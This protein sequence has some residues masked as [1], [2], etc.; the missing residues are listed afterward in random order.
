MRRKRLLI[1]NEEDVPLQMIVDDPGDEDYT[2]VAVGSGEAAVN[3]L[4]QNEI[5][6][7]IVD[8]GFHKMSEIE[9]LRRM[10]ETKPALPI[11]VTTASPSVEAAVEAMKNG[12]SDYLERPLDLSDLER[13]LERTRSSHLTLSATRRA[14]YQ[15]DDVVGRSRKMRRVFRLIE[16]IS[17]SDATVLIQGE[18]GTGKEVIARAI[19]RRSRRAGNAFIT[20]NCAAIPET[21]LESEL[22][23]YEKGAF[24][25]ALL[26]RKGR[27]ELAEGGS[28]LLDEVTEMKPSGQV[29]LLRVLQEKEFRRVGGSRLIRTDVRIIASSNKNVEEEVARG[30]FREDLYYRL[31]V[32]PIHVS[33]LRERKE[34]VPLLIGYFL[35]KHHKEA[36]REIRGISEEAVELLSRHDWPG[37]VRELENVIQRAMVLGKKEHIVSEDL[38]DTI[39][40]LG[41]H[42]DEV[43][44]SVNSSLED[45]E[46]S[47]IKGVL[48]SNGWN[49]SRAARILKI[50]RMTLYNKIKKYGFQ[51]PPRAN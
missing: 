11:V 35:E 20:A 48:S 27:F 40:R 19:H 32:I 42:G 23:G 31:N 17:H 29:D 16:D 8:L 44:Y 39:R 50:N 25:G 36:K 37:N 26:S 47:H 1:V 28:L 18:S 38:P 46:R 43:C 45:V 24:T 21:L 2:I 14:R 9:T 15:F 34:D 49:L 10:R 33:P 3:Q 5:D 6:L 13:R 30:S 51:R 12:A 4:R 7:A 41:T 22:F